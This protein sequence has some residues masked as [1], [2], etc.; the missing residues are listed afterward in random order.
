MGL[1]RRSLRGSVEGAVERL[2][3]QGRWRCGEWYARSGRSEE[4]SEGWLLR[5]GCRPAHGAG[6]VAWKVVV[7]GRGGPHGERCRIRR[8]TRRRGGS[9]RR[10]RHGPPLREE[11]ADAAAQV[12]PRQH[13]VRAPRLPHTLRLRLR[14]RGL[15]AAGREDP[16]RE[17]ASGGRGSVAGV[18]KEQRAEVPGVPQQP[19]RRLAHLAVRLGLVP[20]MRQGAGT[21]GKRQGTVRGRGA[22]KDWKIKR[23]RRELKRP[24]AKRSNRCP[25]L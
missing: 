2:A 17:G 19:P 20:Y 16:W 9:R 6:R 3:E 14:L 22:Q 1:R 5:C 12:R 21:E 15:E 25:Q 24:A 13:H 18:E 4:C 7:E 8:P 10:R 23:R 11:S